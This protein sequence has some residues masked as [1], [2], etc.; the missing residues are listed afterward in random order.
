MSVAGSWT[1][2]DYIINMEFKSLTLNI[3]L[4]FKEK[5][6]LGDFNSFTDYNGTPSKHGKTNNVQTCLRNSTRPLVNKTCKP[7]P[8][9]F[10]IRTWITC[11]RITVTVA[12]WVW[13]GATRTG[14]TIIQATVTMAGNIYN[15][16]IFVADWTWDKMTWMAEETWEGVMWMAEC[17]WDRVMW[18]AES[19][20]YHV[21]RL[22]GA[23]WDIVARFG[24]V[25]ATLYAEYF[26]SHVTHTRAFLADLT[27]EDMYSLM[28]I[29]L[30]VNFC[31][32]LVYLFTTC[33]MYV[34]RRRRQARLD[35]EAAERLAAANAN[36]PV[37]RPK[38]KKKRKKNQKD[39]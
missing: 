27:W 32:L 5:N 37:W 3:K 34:I 30:A 35:K 18:L 28:I 11:K 16:V 25:I 24:N 20:W 38:P 39:W 15:G 8:L 26:K 4:L 17:T 29:I 21:S 9:G 14:N 19:I 13:N 12:G 23:V 31:I 6:D 7:R 10:M 33:G 1:G 36:K 22:A 2:E